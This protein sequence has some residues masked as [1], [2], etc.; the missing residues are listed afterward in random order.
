MGS[1]G[2]L[3]LESD[4]V[5]SDGGNVIC[6]VE[7]VKD[8]TTTIFV[9]SEDNMEEA[10]M[11]IQKGIPTFSM[12]V[13]AEEE[14]FNNAEV[15]K[16]DFVILQ[17][18]K[19]DQDTFVFSCN[20][21]VQKKNLLESAFELF[22]ERME[23]LQDEQAKALGDRVAEL[24]STLSEMA[25]HRDEE[26][27]PRF[28]TTI[29]ER[30]W[31]LSH[32]LKLDELKAGIDHGKAGRD[33]SVVEAHDP[34]AEEKYVDVVNTLGAI[35]FSL[36]S[37]LDSKKDASIVDLVDS[38]CLE[39]TSLSSSP[40]VIN[41]RVQRFRWE[42]K[43]K[44]LSLTDVMTPLIEP[45]SSK[46]LTAEAS[47]SAAPITTLSTAFASS[48]IVPSGSVVNDQISDAEPHNKNPPVVTFKKEELS[49]SQE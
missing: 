41:L 24:D 33:F 43:E 23:A 35:S 31:F 12:I 49:T 4:I 25:I 28:L 30:W 37:E 10:L 42:V 36:L 1:V 39:E 27:Y 15:V 48:A 13:S 14:E 17:G 8:L 21:L 19:L 45:L 34:S 46:I 44:H 20:V 11:A 7:K 6:D 16:T 18:I 2:A 26:F 47:T 40:K 22:R 38:L 5:R 32:A 3:F 29:S 9:A